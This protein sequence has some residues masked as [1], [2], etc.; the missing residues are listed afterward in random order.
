MA[1]LTRL[2]RERTTHS[3]EVRHTTI[4]VLELLHGVAERCM[5]VGEH[6]LRQRLHHSAVQRWA[7]DVVI[8][9]AWAVVQKGLKGQTVAFDHLSVAP[10]W[11]TDPAWRFQEAKG[12]ENYQM[13]SAASHDA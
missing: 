3:F 13:R 11:T 7:E 8:V 6:L 2:G 1:K 4:G 5:V 12:E 10:P 9:E